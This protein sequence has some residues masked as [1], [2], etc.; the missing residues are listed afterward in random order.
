MAS[1][2]NINNPNPKGVPD[3]LLDHFEDAMD[4]LL[5]LGSSP[6][7]HSL[8]HH[9]VESPTSW[10]LSSN[11]VHMEVQENAK[12][13]NL[14]T[15]VDRTGSAR[16]Q[17]DLDET[18]DRNS[19]ERFLQMHDRASMQ[20]N[21]AHTYDSG[22][23][24]Q[25]PDD[26]VREEKTTAQHTE[27]QE[28]KDVD[29]HH[30]PFHFLEHVAVDPTPLS[31]M[32]KT[33]KQQQQQFNYYPY[34]R[35]YPLPLPTKR[36]SPKLVKSNDDLIDAVATAAALAITSTTPNHSAAHAQPRNALQHASQQKTQYGFG[37]NHVVPSV[38]NPPKQEKR[39][40]RSAKSSPT[41]N[42][43]A[44]ERKKQRAKDARVKLNESIDRLNVS[45][46]L[47]GSQSKSRLQYSTT[48]APMMQECM[49]IAE[50]AKKWDR[51]AFVGSAATLIQSLNAQCEALFQELLLL[52]QSKKRTES[53]SSESE[54]ASKRQ[55]QDNSDATMVSDTQ[56]STVELAPSLPSD[57]SVL[58]DSKILNHLA[59]YLDPVSL[60]RCHKVSKRWNESSVFDRE[61]LWQQLSMERF[62]YFNVRQWRG[63]LEDDDGRCVSSTVLYQSMDRANVMPHFAHEHM[64]LL[65]EARIPG[66]V[67][68]WT[69]MV[70]RSNGETLRSVRRQDG[71]YKSLPVVELRTV[72]QN[73]GV[74]SEPIV[75]REQTQTVDAS[76]R[77]RGEEMKEVDWD[78][79]FQKRV[80]HLDGTP[81]PKPEAKIG[82]QELCQ[83][84]LFDTVV[85]E[86]HIHARGCSTSS[87]FVQRANFTKVLISLSSGVTL[88]LVV[89]FPPEHAAHLQH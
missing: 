20:A 14:L 79:R 44:Y 89:T 71:T 29:H 63:K 58:T 12:I 48:A 87:K 23:D 45:I 46:H 72:I 36:T 65:G 82:V 4:D 80:L 34:G 60:A 77:R 47:A 10:R 78:D 42:G 76:T 62:G 52:Q 40:A 38:P 41:H 68:A 9:D 8:D 15:T 83:L 7:H 28:K 75:I 53:P 2:P 22:I 84:K 57:G 64:F 59:N 86:T 74:S 35:S 55:R 43:D 49:E 21:Y 13:P 37:T 16:T 73:T 32:Q 69:F 18:L 3:P 27:E 6:Q 25:Q 54:Q 1:Q 33:D 67:S 11:A 50:G 26:G 51:P 5:A 81:Y 88:P 39:N 31:E 24:K 56:T 19:T 85:L 17:R 66:K 30:D 61:D 70:E